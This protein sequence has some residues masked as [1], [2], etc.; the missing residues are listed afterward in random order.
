MYDEWVVFNL[1][2]SCGREFD[3]DSRRSFNLMCADS[4]FDFYFLCFD[5]RLDRPDMTFTVDWA[6]KPNDLSLYL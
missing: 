2:I 3:F 6:L 5:K 4:D 1:I